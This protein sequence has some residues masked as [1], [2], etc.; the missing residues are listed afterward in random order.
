MTNPASWQPLASLLA[1]D[2][3]LYRARPTSFLL[4]SLVH[5]LGV[6]MVAAVAAYTA[7]YPGEIRPHIDRMIESA[8]TI[9]F[10]GDGGGHGGGG[11]QATDR[12]SK[13]AL[14]RTTLAVQLAA[15][16]VQEPGQ[17][18]GGGHARGLCGSRRKHHSHS[19]K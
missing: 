17:E 2:Q 4:S 19:R 3:R 14:P 5:A 18:R 1:D 11:D 12:A 15:P 8:G 13:G 16:D 6:A 7:R 9:A 10:S